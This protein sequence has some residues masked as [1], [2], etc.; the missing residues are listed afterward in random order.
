MKYKNLEKNEC[1]LQRKWKL[2]VGTVFPGMAGNLHFLLG[3]A[4][5]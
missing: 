5:L 1:T 2:Y 3:A 4:T